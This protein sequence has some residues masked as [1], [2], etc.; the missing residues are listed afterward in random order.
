MYCEEAVV[1]A[2]APEG[3]GGVQL[4]GALYHTAGVP[5]APRPCVGGVRGPG[6]VL[7]FAQHGQKYNHQSGKSSAPE[8]ETIL[9]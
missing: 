8:T 1:L 5:G 9:H 2:L 3:E 7:H 4:G 6:D